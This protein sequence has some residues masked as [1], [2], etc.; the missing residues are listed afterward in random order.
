MN[1][2]QPLALGLLFLGALPRAAEAACVNPAEAVVDDLVDAM[3]ATDAATNATLDGDSNMFAVLSELGPISP[4]NGSTMAFLFTGDVTQLCDLVDYDH[5]EDGLPDGDK[6]TL[7]LE[8]LVPTGAQSLKLDFY[9]LSREYPEFVGG[10][11]NDTFEVNL[12]D[13]TGTSQIVF[14]EAGNVIS[15]NNALFSVTDAGELLETGFDGHGGTGWLRTTTAVTEGDS[16]SLEFSIQDLGDGVLDS[17]VL[18][19]LVEFSED[20][21]DGSTTCPEADSTNDPDGDDIA[22][23]CDNCPDVANADQADSDGDG[24]GDAC[25]DEDSGDTDDTGDPQ[26]PPVWL[27]GGPACSATRSQATPGALFSLLLAFGLVLRRR[28]A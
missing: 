15:V 28:D 16:I 4:R 19:D 24:V 5:G 12:T 27:Q 23:V 3:N 9:F 2:Q 10:E 11:F 14:D 1:L 25:E 20:P 21:A 17:G 26:G 18:L 22:D 13:A 8:A 7:S 6:A